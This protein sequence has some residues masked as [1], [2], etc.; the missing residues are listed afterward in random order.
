MMEKPIKDQEQLEVE[1]KIATE[2]LITE[3]AIPKE[4]ATEVPLSV[5]DGTDRYPD[6]YQTYSP[7]KIVQATRKG[8]RFIF[9][10]ENKI[11]FRIS[12]LESGLFQLT[13]SLSLIH[14]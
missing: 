1:E 4:L 14:I 5:A 6:V 10:C 2:D 3:V 13:Y 9:V 12:I 8:N 11:T 7:D